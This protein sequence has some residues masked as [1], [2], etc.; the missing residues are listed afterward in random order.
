[1]PGVGCCGRPAAAAEPCPREPSQTIA[2][3]RPGVL[4]ELDEE[5]I[6]ARGVGRLPGRGGSPGRRLRGDG[7]TLF[8]VQPPLDAIHVRR[9]V[10]SLALGDERTPEQ[11]PEFA[12]RILVDVACKALSPAVNDP[13]TAVIAI[14]QIHNLLRLVGPAPLDVGERRD[15]RG[16]LRLTY[17]TPGWIDFVLLAVIEIRH[18]GRDSIQVARRLKAMLNDLASVVPPDRAA[19][20]SNSSHCCNGGSSETSRTLRIGCGRRPVTPRASAAR[21]R[22]GVCASD[23]PGIPPPPKSHEAGC[24]HDPVRLGALCRCSPPDG[25]SASPGIGRHWGIGVTGDS[26]SPSLP[27]VAP[28]HGIALL[29][30]S[31]SAWSSTGLR[32]KADAPAPT[33][34]SR[35]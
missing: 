2:N 22:T 24:R 11:D 29:T 19:A 23:F 10:N 33:T 35:A 8:R 12:F 21:T 32:R 14:D 5:G 20:W 13:T 17:P 9:L 31:S 7:A 15:G 16:N 28:L 3:K 30:A 4:L 34:R 27:S 18:Y 6:C 1:M 26:S 25:Q